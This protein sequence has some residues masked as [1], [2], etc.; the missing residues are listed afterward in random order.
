[1]NWVYKTEEANDL[2]NWGVE[3][4]DY[5]INEEGTL[6][7]PENVNAD[8]VGYHQDMGWG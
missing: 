5:I 1:M 3:G 2:L 7:Y 8:N 4:K 6:E